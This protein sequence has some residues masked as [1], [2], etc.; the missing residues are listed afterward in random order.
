MATET[1]RC[2][3]CGE[4]CN[5]KT[6]NFV[7]GEVLCEKCYAEYE[8]AKESRPF[9]G[10]VCAIDDDRTLKHWLE[11]YLPG[12]KVSQVYGIPEDETELARYDVLIVD[13][14]GIGN[15]QYG[16]GM[17]FLLSYQMRGNNKGLVHF[18]NLVSNADK[19]ALAEK[20]IKYL[21]KCTDPQNLLDAVA[22]FV[23][24]SKAKA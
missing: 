20:G 23:E 6:K 2:S 5:P 19:I 16:D 21:N 8:R 7:Q 10:E 18:S 22:G 9:R 14:Y 12:F 24:G 17:E 15:G 1:E 13:G 11:L 3:R 4:A